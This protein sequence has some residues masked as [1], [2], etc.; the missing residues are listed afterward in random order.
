MLIF[1]F[2]KA[3]KKVPHRRLAVKLNYYG[4]RGNLLTWIKSFLQNKSQLVVVDG[5]YSSPIT[6]CSA[7]NSSWS[8]TFPF[9]YQWHRHKHPKWNKT[10]CRWLL[11]I[12]TNKFSWWSCKTT[13]RPLFLSPNGLLATTWQMEFNVD[14]LLQL[15]KKHTNSQFTYIMNGVPSI[16]VKEHHYLDILLND[17]LSWCSHIDQTC[18]ILK[19]SSRI[20]ELIFQ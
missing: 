11:H 6:G 13:P 4:I 18:N 10:I 15:S 9:I 8:H 5:Q 20:P 7:R 19:E 12:Q 2:S 1:D 14:H 17:K 16:T 3:F